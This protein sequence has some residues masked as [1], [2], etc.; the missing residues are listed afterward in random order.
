MLQGSS[1]VPLKREGCS[2]P[3]QALAPASAF[4]TPVLCGCRP[5][6][7]SFPCLT[8]PA[9]FR[10]PL[11]PLQ[12]PRNMYQCQMAKQTMGTPCQALQH[13]CVCM[14]ASMHPC[15][16]TRTQTRLPSGCA[17]LPLCT[18]LCAGCTLCCA[19]LPCQK[20][21]CLAAVPCCAVL[22]LHCTGLS[23]CSAA[24]LLVHIWGLTEYTC[25][26]H[27][28]GQSHTQDSALSYHPYGTCKQR[29]ESTRTHA[30]ASTRAPSHP[31]DR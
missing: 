7:C 4:C 3:L 11:S 13:R 8:L 19:V 23:A 17:V 2:L 15:V 18:G 21:S 29:H 10:L 14:Q 6:Y 9:C 26:A 24:E 12:S 20:M 30:H 27:R 22:H 1:W 28:S 5:L 31:Q 25:P 16:C